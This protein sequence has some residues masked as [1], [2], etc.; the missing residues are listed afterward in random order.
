MLFN[1]EIFKEKKV[2]Q[3]NI[4]NFCIIAHVDHGKS[5]LADQFLKICQQKVSKYEKQVLDNMPLEKER[6]ITIKL[7]SCQLY[8]H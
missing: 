7:S 6:G 1:K 8:Y 4:R 5:T 3:Q 2:N